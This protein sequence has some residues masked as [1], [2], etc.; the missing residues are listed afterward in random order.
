MPEVYRNALEGKKLSDILDPFPIPSGQPGVNKFVIAQVTF[1]DE[2]GEYTLAEMRERIRLQ[3]SEERSM[4][5]LIDTLKKQTYISVRYDPGEGGRRD[6]PVTRAVPDARGHCASRSRW[7]IRAA[8]ARKSPR[9]ALSDPR[10]RALEVSWRVVGPSGT[11]QPVDEAIGAWGPPGTRRPMPRRAG[12]L[13]GRAVLRAADLAL[14]GRGAGH[15][16]GAAR[17][18]RA[19]GGRLRLPRAH[20]D[21]GA[22]A[23]G[24]RPP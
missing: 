13:A 3:L 16:D 24:S 7:A 11:E 17:Q 19:A 5:R 18:G 14:A 1:L 4:R 8:S 2:A 22:L 15:R 21:A 12:A 10:V 9:K 20:R 6:R 23:P